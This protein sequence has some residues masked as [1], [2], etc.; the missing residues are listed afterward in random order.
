M[1]TLGSDGA[2]AVNQGD[3]Y[4]KEVYKTKTIDAIGTG[5]SFIG[6]FI[7]RIAT[8]ALPPETYS[9]RVISQ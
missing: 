5:D 7:Y 1:V 8:D 2:L 9:S 4:R 3:T 6:G